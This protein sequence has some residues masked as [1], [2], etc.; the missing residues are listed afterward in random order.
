MEEAAADPDLRHARVL[1]EDVDA[2]AKNDREDPALLLHQ[3]RRAT[4]GL[5]RQGFD[6]RPQDFLVEDRRRRIIRVLDQQFGGADG[7]PIGKAIAVDLLDRRVHDDWERHSVRARVTIVSPHELLPAEIQAVHRGRAPRVDHRGSFER[8]TPF[9]GHRT[10]TDRRD[11]RIEPVLVGP[12]RTPQNL[13]EIA[14][15]D[16]VV[17][18][19]DGPASLGKFDLVLRPVTRCETLQQP[20]VLGRYIRIEEGPGVIAAEACTLLQQQ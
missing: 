20:A 4:V 17:A 14:R 11:P 8:F 10:R 12:Q 13:I 16:A 15:S 7:Q 1:P 18:D 5:H 2:P 6:A 19:R 3:A 9:Q